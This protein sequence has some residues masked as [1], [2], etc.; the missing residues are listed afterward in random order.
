MDK[1]TLNQEGI[2]KEEKVGYLKSKMNLLQGHLYLTSK[3]LVLEA[4]KTTVGGGILGAIL[5]KKVEKKDYGFNLE[6]KDIKNFEQGKQGLNKNI[7]EVNTSQG[8]TYRIV[9]KK[10]NDWQEELNKHL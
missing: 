3:R 4:H 7:L 9:V 8:E 2:L 10:Y 5:K 1:Q 6:F